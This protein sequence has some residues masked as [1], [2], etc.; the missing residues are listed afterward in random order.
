[1]IAS[2]RKRRRLIPVL[3][4][5]LPALAVQGF[6][7]LSGS[8]LASASATPTATPADLPLAPSEESFKPTPEML[9]AAKWVNDT[10]RPGTL[11]ALASPMDHPPP[12]DPSAP[13]PTKVATP[14]DAPT[15]AP[16]KTIARRPTGKLALSSIISGEGGVMAFIN[17]KIFRVGDAVDAEWSITAI[18]PRGMVVS[19]TGPDGQVIEL[20][21]KGIEER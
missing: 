20:S 7:A 19:I 15:P 10:V 13:P 5:L 2:A 12:P 4:L 9:A 8:G 17:G 16:T 3:A 14:T 1:M 21:R 11:A 6:R 18:D